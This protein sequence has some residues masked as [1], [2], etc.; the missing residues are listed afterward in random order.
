MRRRIVECVPNFS[1]GRDARIVDAIEAAIARG[2]GIA[3]L[4]KTMD[5]DHNR[6]VIT[7]A[8]SPEAVVEA[9]LRG[10][11]KAAELID[12]NTHEGV[13]PRI[14]ATDVFPF[15]PVEG[16]TLTECAALAVST[17]EEIWRRLSI[18][19]YL[20]EA[21]ARRPERKRLEVIRRGQFEELRHAAAVDPERRPDIGGPE[22]HPTAGATVVGARS[23]LIAYNINLATED[24]AVAQRIARSIRA[25][26]GGFPHVKALGLVLAS[27]KQ[28]QVSMNL[29]DF[30]ETPVHVVFEEVRRQAAEAGVEIAGSEIIGLIPKAA[31]EMAA[32]YFLRCENFRPDMVVENRL[33]EELPYTI[34]DALDEISDPARGAG[35]GS[36]AALAGGIAAALGVLS[37]RLMKRDPDVFLQHRRFFRHAADRD[38]HAFAALMRT[39]TPA[40]EAVLEATEAPLSIAE[41]AAALFGDLRELTGQCPQR[42]VSDVFT[43]VGLAFSA[44]LGAASTV[45]LNLPRIDDPAIRE[46]M[47]KRLQAIK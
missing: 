22:L 36:A 44:K 33:A 4:G 26:S 41:R 39:S 45:E 24:G 25:S 16:V 30:R 34:D 9:A 7:F 11:A 10:V 15:V 12:L 43:A 3:V 6:S 37:C 38:A 19:I 17:A 31:I 28:T 40:E 42:Y 23:F 14:G 46:S 8:G 29:T 20:Y 13:H 35:G 1:E 47:D 2:P 27:R 18:P 32:D 21:A 5:A